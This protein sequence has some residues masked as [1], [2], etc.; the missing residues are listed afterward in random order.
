MYEA[1]SLKFGYTAPPCRQTGAVSGF[2]RLM[3]SKQGVYLLKYAR[4]EVLALVGVGLSG[5]A[6]SGE[7][8]RLRLGRQQ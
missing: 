4:L 7:E 6:K 3:N 2:P 1:D 8:L 5:H